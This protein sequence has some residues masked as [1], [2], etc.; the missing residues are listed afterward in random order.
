MNAS[1]PRWKPPRLPGPR[2]AVPRWAQSIKFRLAVTY[3]A[4]VYAVG[5]ILIG[6]LYVWQVNQLDHP[7]LIA[8]QGWIRD[9]RNGQVYEVAALTTDSFRGYLLEVFELNVN[10]MAIDNLKRASLVGLLV[11]VV[12]AFVIGWILATITLRPINRMVAVARDISASDLSRRIDLQGHDDELRSLAD[13]F[14]A[15]L[16]RLQNAFEDQRRF[17][18]DASHELRNPLAVARTNLELAL[19]NPDAGTEELRRSVEVAH[20]STG[21]M[22]DLVD[23]LLVQAR[24]GVP[25]IEPVEV[26]LASVAD[27]VRQQFLGPAR[28]RSIAID[29]FTSG[30]SVV[31]GDEPSLNRVVTNLVSNALRFAPPHTAI[32]VSV[33]ST[34]DCHVELSV[35]DQGPG[36]SAEDRQQVFTRFWRGRNAGTGS[37]LGLSI[38][39]QVVERHG[40]TVCVNSTPGDGATFVV[41]L[42]RSATG[43]GRPVDQ[44]TDELDESTASDATPDDTVTHGSELDGSSRS[45]AARETTVEESSASATAQA[46]TP[47]QGGQP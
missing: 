28:E 20:R 26:D 5:S 16:D 31:R 25:Q 3:A 27:D 46:P 35:A 45:T 10:L 42:P 23:D 34:D 1:G 11:L 37:G 32:N 2:W 9:S 12:V 14:D 19:S 39:K 17:V 4:T 21:R 24:S 47:A 15:M 13:T 33:T 44:R 7:Q 22:S 40:G 18:Q 41:R 43:T 8:E 30:S 38:V 6:A 36:L 29:R